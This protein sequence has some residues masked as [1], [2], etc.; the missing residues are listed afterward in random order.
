MYE[1]IKLR[2]Y[3]PHIDKL[4]VAYREKKQAMLQAADEYLAPLPGVHWLKPSGG[5]YVW[6]TLPQ[7]ID[8]GP[9]GTLFERAVQQGMLY[10]PGQYCYPGEG[11]CQKNTIRLSFGVQT[12][13][14][15]RR[16]IQMLAAAIQEELS[17]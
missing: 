4:R 9:V 14:Q 5:L 13:P 15:I 1:V 2:L 7:S 12:A 16:G 11:P 3:E 8:T 6:L 10:V 17:H